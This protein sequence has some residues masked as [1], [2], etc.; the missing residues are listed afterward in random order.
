MAVKEPGPAMKSGLE[1]IKAINVKAQ[2]EAEVQEDNATKDGS[3]EV[4]K[5][6]HHT[7]KDIGHSFEP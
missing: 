5:E 6:E 1:D 3:S 7:G 4:R 2:C